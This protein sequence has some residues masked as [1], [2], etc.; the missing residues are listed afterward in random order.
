MVRDAGM[1]E[2]ATSEYVYSWE[3]RGLSTK[4]A[5]KKNKKIELAFLSFS[6]QLYTHLLAKLPSS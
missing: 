6:P 1:D 4:A 2:Y 3:A 5:K